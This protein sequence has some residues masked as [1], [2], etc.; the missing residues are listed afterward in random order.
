MGWQ[1]WKYA[2]GVL[3]D[4]RMPI[5]LKGKA[6]HMVVRSAILYGSECWHIKKSQ[7][8]RL[9]AAEMRMIRWM[10]GYIRIVKIRN[11]VIRDLVKVVPIEDKIRETRLI[12]FGHMKRRNMN[13]TM[14]RCERI[15]IPAGKR[16]RGR[17]KKSLNEVIREDLKVVGLT[18]D[19]AQ[20]RRL[21]RDRIRTLDRRELPTGLHF[22]LFYFV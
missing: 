3:C 18:E 7:L 12:W 10:Y 1:K 16:G 9:M 11:E 5:G 19:L 20:D 4:K 22:I 6:Y 2:S 15:N 17:P 14:R 21:L 8:Q 13:A